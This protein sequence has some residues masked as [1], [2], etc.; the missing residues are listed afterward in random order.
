MDVTAL[1]PI[2][3]DRFPI[4]VVITGSVLAHPG[5]V[6]SYVN[7]AFEQMAGYSK[8]ELIGQSPRVLQGPR[9]SPHTK[10]V[11][12]RTLLRGQRFHGFLTNYRK[13]GEE[14]QCEVD[15]RPLHD[16]AG[17]VGAFIAFEREVVRRRGRPS[18]HSRFIALDNVEITGLFAI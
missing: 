9:T 13:G 11:M 17:Q 18:S 1:I 10:R 14:Y 2:L 12:M 3:A 6:I 4:P 7:P 5:P 8:G 15:V 16:T